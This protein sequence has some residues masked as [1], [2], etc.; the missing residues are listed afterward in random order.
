M[1]RIN[2]PSEPWR[3]PAGGVNVPGLFKLHDTHGLHVADACS[4]LARRGYRGDIMGFVIEA[5]AAGWNPRTVAALAREALHA[6]RE[7]RCATSA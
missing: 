3:D 4:E 5:L 6:E 1:T 2:W 7:A